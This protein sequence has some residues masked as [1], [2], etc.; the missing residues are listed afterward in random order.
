MPPEVLA[1]LRVPGLGQGAVLRVHGESDRCIS[2]QLL[3][4]GIWEPF[5]TSLVQRFLG[6]GDVFVDVGANLGYFT[7]LAA[8]RVGPGGRV[9]AFEPDPANFALLQ[10]NI[11]RNA[12]AAWAQAVRAGLAACD[13][14]AHLHLSDDN[15]GDH[16]L[17]DTGEGRNSV[18]VSLL[19]GGAWLAQRSDRIAMIKIDTQGYEHEVMRGLLPLLQRLPQVPRILIEL[20]PLSLRQAGSSGR[21]LVTLLA[22]LGQPLWIVDHVEHRLVLSSAGELARWCDNVDACPG[23]A[24]FMNL[25]VGAD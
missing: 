16:Q 22:E 19:D 6:S 15:L 12:C 10:D 1:Q 7:V 24:G 11:E 14:A 13:G 17:F 18:A 4:Q 5:E 25:L 8:H 20:T 21:A 23:D 9:F 3:E 2:R